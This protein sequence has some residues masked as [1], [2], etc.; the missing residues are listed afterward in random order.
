MRPI[1][2]IKAKELVAGITGYYEHGS[3]MTF[4]LVEIKAGSQLPEH[5]HPQEQITYM[6]TGQLDMII[7]GESCILTPGMVQVI[8]PNVLHSAVAPVDCTLIDV[9]APVREDYK[10]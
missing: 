7:G 9:F 5:S 8:P 4:G 10:Q 1:K 2:D 6:L 3:Q